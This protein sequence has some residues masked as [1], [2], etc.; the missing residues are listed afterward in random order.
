[1][2]LQNLIQKKEQLP[3]LNYVNTLT[4]QPFVQEYYQIHRKKRMK[5]L[6]E[7]SPEATQ[8]IDGHARDIAGTFHF[9]PV[10]PGASG[11]ILINKANNFVLRSNYKQHRF[12]AIKD[13]IVTGEGFL[14]ISELAKS[15]A[16][17][18]VRE[19]KRI[20]PAFNDNSFK[21]RGIM[22]M[23]STTMAVEHNNHEVTRY[24]QS[25]YGTA[26]GVESSRQYSK[27][28]VMHITF[29]V[30]A[31]K[32]EGWTPLYTVPLHLELLWLM[33]DNQ[34]DFQVRGNHPDLVVMAETLD[35][36]KTSF[37]K[38]SKD[39][40]AYN[41]PGNSR[42]GTLLLAGDK[43]N[44]Q[45]LERMD[46]LQFKEVDMFIQSLLGGLFH[47]PQNRLA[48][49]TEQSAKSKD[50]S[51][52]NERFYYSIIEQKQDVLTDIENRMFWM[53]YFGVRIVQDKTYKHDQIEEGTAQQIRLGNLNMLAEMLNARGRVL[54]TRKA[55]DVFNG[56][57]TTL[58]EDD[59]EEG[60]LHTQTS[61]TTND[62]LSNESATGDGM[63]TQDRAEK[64]EEE[65]NREKVDGKPNGA[66]R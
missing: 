23:A 60:Q 7:R 54:N 37:D 45:Q 29:E 27:D 6:V 40:Q 46:T 13:A 22:S 52:G 26:G 55:I 41:M 33:W 66:S 32:V 36:N 63:S 19:F 4:K 39:L 58:S 35:R 53:P 28:K 2:I 50:S 16:D 10:R 48:I 44:I 38:V 15:Q 30:P 47:Y 31:G 8:V 49:K 61:S 9:E 24:I 20:D 14:F 56:V 51:G 57:G 12:A 43:F 59:V 42:H 5:Y 62:R 18:L 1:M 3:L 34:Y 25:L 21:A 11:K 64:R 17:M 65:L